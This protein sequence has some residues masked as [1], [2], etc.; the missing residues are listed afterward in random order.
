MRSDPHQDVP[1]VLPLQVNHVDLVRVEGAPLLLIERVNLTGFPVTVIHIHGVARAE[2]V[3]EQ[4]GS[5][6]LLVGKLFDLSG[7]GS[8]GTL[9]KLASTASISANAWIESSEEG[10]EVDIFSELG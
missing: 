1:V 5:L 10:L 8:G 9:I 3:E 7:T 6:S 4:L 2:L